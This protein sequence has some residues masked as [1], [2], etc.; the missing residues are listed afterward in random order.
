MS[1]FQYLKLFLSCVGIGTIP[2]GGGTVA[3]LATIPLWWALATYL[4]PIWYMVLVFLFVISCIYLCQIYE[5][6]TKTHDS[7]LIVIDEV[8]G[9]LITMTWL[10]ITWQSAVIGFVLFR[11][12]DIVKP[13]PIGKLDKNVKGGVGV[14][15]DDVAAGVFSNFL[16]QLLYNFTSIL[17]SQ[18]ATIS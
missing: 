15:L 11:F 3:T 17:G 2:K 14:M 1:Q 13:G 12:F 4:N 6:Q 16:L 9:F 10:P 7:S 5:E 8:A 18:I